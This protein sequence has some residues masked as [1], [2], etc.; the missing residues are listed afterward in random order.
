[1]LSQFEDQRT[2]SGLET[3]Q[4]LSYAYVDGWWKLEVGSKEQQTSHSQRFLILFF[5][6]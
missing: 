2:I 6:F 4:I 1:M 5:I 3:P